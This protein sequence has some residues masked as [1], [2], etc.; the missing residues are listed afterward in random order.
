MKFSNQYLFHIQF[1]G[2]RYH[3]WLKHKELKT[4][5]GMVDKTFVFLFGHE[6]FKTLGCSRTDAKVSALHFVFELFCEDQ[7]E[8]SDFLD[9]FN[10]GLPNDIRCLKIEKTVPEF[11]IIQAPKIK[12]YH[13]FFSSGKKNHPFSAPSIMSVDEELDIELMKEGAQLFLGEHNFK[14]YCAKPNDSKNFRRQIVH[15]EIYLNKEIIGNFIPSES[16][17]FKVRSEGFLRY[18][19]RLMMGQLFALGKKEITI[20]DIQQSLKDSNSEPVKFIAPS[21]GLVLAAV[22]FL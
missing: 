21:S 22:D 10:R 19:V 7:I 15:S 5:Q 3:G 11:N 13:Y 1:L 12:E 9:K 20:S 2:Y 4:V 16:Y 8:T 18:Q 17:V 6:N 14:G